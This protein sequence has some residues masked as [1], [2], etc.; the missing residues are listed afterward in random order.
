[1]P[2][3]LTD[4]ELFLVRRTHERTLRAAFNM[5]LYG[6]LSEGMVQSLL[7]DPDSVERLREGATRDLAAWE[8]AHA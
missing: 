7:D 8:A 4:R 1:M 6:L 2:A 3:P 5:S